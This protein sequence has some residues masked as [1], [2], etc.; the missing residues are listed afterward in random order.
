MRNLAVFKIASI[1][2]DTLT[3]A[4]K[5][6]TVTIGKPFYLQLKGTNTAE[7]GIAAT[8]VVEGE[9]TTYT[10][11]TGMILN[12]KE[13]FGP[14]VSENGII[15]VGGTNADVMAIIYLKI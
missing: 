14:I 15:Y 8:A 12:V 3:T 10:I 9:T 13:L 7:F 1:V 5:K 6:I 11:T 2:H 4:V